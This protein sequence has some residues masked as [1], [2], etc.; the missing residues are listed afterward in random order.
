MKRILLIVTLVVLFVASCGKTGSSST[1]KKIDL[2][3]TLVINV[4]EEGKSYDPQLAND[5]TGELVDSLIGEGLIRDGEG[6][7]PAPGVAEKWDISE[8][9]LTWTFYLRKN[10]KWSNGD[11]ITANDFKAGWLRALNQDTA[12]EYAHMIYPVKNA[13][14]YNKGEVGPENVGIEV[15]DDYTL[16]VTLESPLPY[17]D[18]MVKIFTYMPLNEKFFSTVGEKYMTSPETAISSGAYIIKSWTRD[19][20][21]LFE[22]N[23]N[24][25][26]KDAIKLEAVQ[27]KF[28]NDSEASLNAFKN[29]E[30]DITNITTEQAK[31]Y[32]GDDRLW[33]TKNG[34][35]YYMTF[36]LKNPV[37]SNK[38]IRQALT[39]AIDREELVKEVLSG[40]GKTSY[41][42]TVK[43]SGIFGVEKDFPEEAG[44]VFPKFDVVKAKQLLEE[45]LKELG[46]EKLPQLTYIFNESGNNK[47]IAEY[48]QESIRK[49]LG[50]E[51]GIES[52]TFKERLGRMETKDYDIAYAGFAGDYADAISYLERF[53]STNGNNY[54]QYVNPRYDALAR[55]IKSSANQ[56][57]RV[58]KMIELEKIIA[59]DMPV[60]LLYFS[61]VTK[62]V[63]PRVKGLVMIPIGNDYQ[64]G[65]VYLEN[66]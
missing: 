35:T 28:I 31:S 14:N 13:E 27:I 39:L 54:S 56:K 32:V 8:D 33:L 62:L 52:M 20:D 17:F 61:E 36:N 3:K 23:P 43:D 44:D 2:S 7:K 50:V 57:E 51:I 65:N 11:A 9:G 63:N 30:V 59:E 1:D 40:V 64:L 45:G 19:S 41:T 58:S 10:A 24:Y 18:K 26:N 22:K 4:K 12:S 37:L 47:A 5:S 66:K 60:G 16:K 38:K 21:I 42:Y 34:A 53:E 15:V 55:E 25:W 48:I 46:I 49:N 29:G 6:G